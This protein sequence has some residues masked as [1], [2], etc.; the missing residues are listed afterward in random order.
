MARVKYKDYAKDYH[1]I[2]F[3]HARKGQY[4]CFYCGVPSQ[5]IDHFIPQVYV[6]TLKS[7]A[8]INGVTRDE[9][10]EILTIQRFIP[11]CLECNG[12]ASN[13]VFKNP[14][15]KKSYIKKK[16]EVKYKKIINLPKWDEDE[17][18]ELSYLLKISVKSGLS[19]KQIIL[20]RLAW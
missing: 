10:V 5:S 7:L 14:D 2:A 18:E 3:K 9:S 20:G 13:I 4:P 12:I 19:N 8:E 15:Q 6:E 11:A 17:I 16:L 1:D